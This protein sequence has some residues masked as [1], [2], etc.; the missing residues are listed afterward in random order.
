MLALTLAVTCLLT[1]CKS[2]S[3]TNTV[4][5]PGG[6][7]VVI[8]EVMA[9]NNDLWLGH[10]LDWIELYNTGTAQVDL[11]AYYLTDNMEEPTALSLQGY[12]LAPNGYLVIEL[13]ETAPFHLSSQGETVYL[14]DGKNAGA[15]LTF[16][17]STK[18]ESFDAN[19]VCQY[20]TPGFENSKAG[21]ELYV[22]SLPAPQLVIN[23]IMAANSKYLPVKGEYYDMVEVKNISSQAIDLSAYS[24][25]DKKKEPARYTFPKVTLQPGEFYVVYCSG[26]T[27]LGDNHASFKLS[28]ET[29]E[30]V[31]LAQNQVIL[32]KVEIPAD[33]VENESYGRTGNGFAY[34]STPTF[35]KENGNGHATGLVG[36]Q[37][38]LPSGVYDQAQTVTLTAT[39]TIYYTL[40]GTTPTKKSKVYTSPISVKGVTTLRAVGFEGNRKTPETAYTYV[41]G[42][43]AHQLPIV[44]VSI[45]QDSLTHKDTGILNHIKK[46][47]E[48]QCQV[49]LIEGGE[50]K[51]SL[52]CGFRLHGY[53]SREMPKQNF[54]LR[55][56]SQYG[57]S[58]LKYKLFENREFDEFD[59]LLLKGGSEDWGAAVMRDEVATTMLDGQTALYT[60]AYK[61]VVLYLGGEY[62]GIYYLRERFSDDYV[63]S[64][65]NVEEESV[66]LLTSTDGYVQTGS[67]KEFTAL[68]NYVQTH[69]M[70]KDEHYEYLCSQIDA[71]SLMD[72][73]ICRS[74]M[75]D[76]DLANIRRFRTTQG[77][78]KWRWMYFDLDWAFY[79]SNDEPL[80]GIVNDVNG[81][82]ILIQALLKHK[83]GKDALLKRYAQLMSTVLNEQTVN[84]TLDTFVSQVQSEI[85]R[86]R[87]R[88]GCS[89][90]SW[91]SCIE[92]IRNYFKDGKRDARVKADLQKYFK[93]TD[94]QMKSYFG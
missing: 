27:G 47:Y 62:W 35:G 12:T 45:P 83:N 20:V 69:D 53:G 81:E 37:A 43:E 49:T 78:G 71:T 46:T 17:A 16:G 74:Y 19:G 50:E 64:H 88:W 39:G 29:L 8:N 56:R 93:L 38:S 5:A 67:A 40:D 70:S 33:L 31:Y 68:K 6:C 7:S 41:I 30:T 44:T 77:D 57:A 85:E 82:P 10:S 18:G 24:L 76:K 58:K 4:S 2:A 66:D 13:P 52:P 15:S 92:Q 87:A 80:S 86:D 72:W 21:Y 25:S 9:D 89:V 54:Q 63:A 48:Y 51:F 61:P 23:E 14:T 36:P 26:D 79:I 11:S 55:F 34:F 3:E 75:G 90:S 60:Q 94:A 65:L 59:S 22:K 84:Q 42:Q 73:Y 91:E 32:D 1:G 28:M